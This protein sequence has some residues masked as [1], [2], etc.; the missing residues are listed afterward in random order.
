MKQHA[1]ELDKQIVKRVRLRYLLWL[2][3]GYAANAE[4]TWPLILFLHGRGERGSDL[5][6]ITRY[7][8]PTRLAQGFALPAI[9]AAPQCPQ[10]SDWTLQDDA[11]LALLDELTANYAV[12]RDRVYLTGLSMGAR[13]TW[14]L[15]AVHAERFAALAPICGRRPDGVRDLEDARSLRGLPIWVFHGA[16]DQVVPVEESDTIVAALRTCGADVRYTVYADAGHDSWTQ[17]FA[18]PELYSWLLGQRRTTHQVG[19]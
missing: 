17:A 3:D 16:Q 18:E 5:S 1:A 19:S 9:V 4:L 6:S 14:R 15:A 2:P 10:G 13:E 8:L 11:L 7:G 12:D